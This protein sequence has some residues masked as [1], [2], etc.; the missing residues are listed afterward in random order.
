MS[1]TATD[2][3]F[4]ELRETVSS[5]LLADGYTLRERPAPDAA[6]LLVVEDAARR[7]F[8]VGQKPARPDVLVLQGTVS[9]GE[10]HARRIEALPDEEREQ[11][12]YEL[13]FRLLGLGL[14]F[15]GVAHPLRQVVL[16]EHLYR[17]GMRRN[18]FFQTLKRVRHGIVAVIWT[19]GRKLRHPAPPEESPGLP[20]N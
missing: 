15:Q 5:W 17:E 19:V 12:L 10:E 8:M 18:D 16:S 1:E 14:D 7:R 13:R 4:R 2:V 9:L 20:V 6:W 11:F 3:D